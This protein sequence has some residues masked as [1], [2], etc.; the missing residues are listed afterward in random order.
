MQGSLSASQGRI[1]PC[2]VQSGRQMRLMVVCAAKQKQQAQRK[3]EYGANC[4]CTPKHLQQ[5]PVLCAAARSCYLWLT[6]VQSEYKHLYL[7]QWT[8]DLL[9][10]IFR[11]VPL[12]T[13]PAHKSRAVPD[14]GRATAHC[15]AA[16][17]NHP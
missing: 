15:L 2:H 16:C 9:D 14:N 11:P 13:M 5:A 1:V 12:R 7:R 6:A 3:V 10:G 17:C 4:E 8:V